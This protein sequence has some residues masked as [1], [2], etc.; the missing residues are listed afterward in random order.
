[1]PI[2]VRLGNIDRAR[3]TAPI[4]E[5]PG[6]D[7]MNP[8][9]GPIAGL[10]FLLSGGLLAAPT[11]AATIWVPQHEPTIQAAIDAAVLKQDG[12]IAAYASTSVPEPKIPYYPLQHRGALVRLVTSFHFSRATRERA[13]A[14]INFMLAN[15]TLRPTIGKILPLEEIAE[16]HRL[17]ESG[18]II[19]NV[20]VSP[21]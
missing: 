21:E 6:C 4:R 9:L 12:I 11:V 1:M 10:S 18:A 13:L 20:V 5:T 7:S 17:K 19:G 2:P 8:T 3:K 15:G 14:D 16:A